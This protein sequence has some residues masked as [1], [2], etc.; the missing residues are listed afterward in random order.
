MCSLSKSAFNDSV[1]VVLLGSRARQLV[2]FSEGFLF[3]SAISTGI[4]YANAMRVNDL[5]S[6]QVSSGT[7]IISL[8]GR[9]LARL[10]A[11]ERRTNDK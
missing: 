7:L 8:N 5:S 1:R 4:S 6:I 10:A 11:S 2:A 3:Y 9:K